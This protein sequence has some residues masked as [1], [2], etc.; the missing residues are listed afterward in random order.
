MNRFIYSWIFLLCV[1]ATGC[2][3]MFEKELPPH[4]LVGENAITNES[5][6]EVALNGI[7]SYLTSYGTMS[8][9]YISDNEY[10]TG[11]LD[12]TYRTAFEL[13]QLLE[14]EMNDEDGYVSAHWQLVYIMV[15]W[16]NYLKVSS[17]RTGKQRCWRKQSLLGL[18]LT[19]FYFGDMVISGIQ[20]VIT[21]RLSGWNLPLFQII[22]KGAVL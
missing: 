6:A 12:S 21:G 19:H 5:S 14:F 22:I 7:Y 9:Y 15:T 10:R 11:L 16:R 13:N 18:L 3:S 17:G 8:A 20:I 1:L 4:N 2:D